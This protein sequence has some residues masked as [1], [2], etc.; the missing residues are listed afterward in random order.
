MYHTS[1]CRNSSRLAADVLLVHTYKS[2]S[3]SIG[4]P[5]TRGANVDSDHCQH[6]NRTSVNSRVKKLNTDQTL[7][8]E[9]LWQPVLS[10]L[11][12]DRCSNT[13]GE[14]LDSIRDQ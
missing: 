4:H 2:V 1:V 12:T 6:S 10:R 5:L 9:Q 7:L 3:P 11:L 8:L 13:T 14:V